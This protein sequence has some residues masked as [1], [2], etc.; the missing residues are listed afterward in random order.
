MEK[1][2]NMF[3]KTMDK[4]KL[5]EKKSE[6]MLSI[7]KKSKEKKHNLFLKPTF[8]SIVILLLCIINVGIVFASNYN[9]W[10]TGV[11]LKKD[12]NSQYVCGKV[13]EKLNIKIK[14]DEFKNNNTYS[15]NIIEEKLETN[16]LK[17]NYLKKDGFNLE[18]N[19]NDENITNLLLIMKDG[20]NRESIMLSLY[21]VTIHTKDYELQDKY[22]LCVANDESEYYYIKSLKTNAVITDLSGGDTHIKVKYITFTYNKMIYTISIYIDKKDADFIYEFLESLKEN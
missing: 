11:E 4:I 7:I 14:T 15:Y 17:S 3:K 16:I 6:E 22:N 9:K 18:Y 21:T 10:L 8:A 2:S 13:F 1:F 12:N 5:N 19:A 20:I